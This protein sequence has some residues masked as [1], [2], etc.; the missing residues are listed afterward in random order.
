M[1]LDKRTEVTDVQVYF[2]DKL[3]KGTALG[4]KS[5]GKGELDDDI[6]II[7]IINK[8]TYTREL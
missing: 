4:S 1:V 2:I 5:W 3:F 8:H 7:I 6:I